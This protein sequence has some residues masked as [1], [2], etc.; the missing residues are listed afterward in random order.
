MKKIASILLVFV[1]IFALSPTVA[2]A[3]DVITVTADG[4]AVVFTDQNPVIVN[5][6][7]L[8]PVAGVF[9][10]L[11]FTTEWNSNTRQV[12]ITRDSDVIVL[13]IGST[14]FTTNSVSHTLDV[15]AQIIG[16]RTMLPIAIVL[17]SVGYEVDWNSATRT[18]TIIPVND[19]TYTTGYYTIND[20]LLAGRSTAYYPFAVEFFIVEDDEIVSVH[21]LIYGSV[22]NAFSHWANLNNVYDVELINYN[23]IMSSN[24]VTLPSGERVTGTNRILNLELSP[25]FLNYASG[26]NSALLIDSLMKTFTGMWRPTVGR[27]RIDIDF[28]GHILSVA[29]DF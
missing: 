17:R 7:T 16:G 3:N 8:V 21:Y 2:F 18:V 23:M 6:R 24:I 9:Q 20:F 14:T 11:G 1:M 27:M 5:G 22:W 29:T 10:A 12:T 26:D 13:T 28:D 4:Q 25:E 15:P 19:T